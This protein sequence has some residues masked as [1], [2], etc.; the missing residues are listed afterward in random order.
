ML[1][2]FWAN[3]LLNQRAEPYTQTCKQL[4]YYNHYCFAKVLVAPLS[5]TTLYMPEGNKEIFIILSEA[6]SLPEYTHLPVMS[7]IVAFCIASVS[8][9]R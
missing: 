7:Y 2:L 8:P 4:S 5:K 9:L 6:L 3:E 1:T